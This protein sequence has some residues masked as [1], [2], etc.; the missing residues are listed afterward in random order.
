MG[1]AELCQRRRDAGGVRNLERHLVGDA[2]G[3]EL[4]LGI[5]ERHRGRGAAEV[6]GEGR[7]QAGQGQQQGRLADAVRPDQGDEF[8]A[9]KVEVDAADDRLTRTPHRHLAR[10][11][12]HVAE[13]RCWLPG[14][15]PGQQSEVR[16]R[17]QATSDAADRD[18]LGLERQPVARP[19][20]GVAGP[21]QH[22]G[23]GTGRHDPP[24]LVERQGALGQPVDASRS[25][26][27]VKTM[28]DDHRGGVPA[29]RA[30]QHVTE[31]GDAGRVEHRGRLVEHQQLRVVDAGGR[32]P[33]PLQ[34]AARQFGGVPVPQPGRTD[35]RQGG[36][37]AGVDERRVDRGTLQHQS[38]LLFDG[39]QA[40]RCSGILAEEAQLLE[41]R[42]HHAPG[43]VRGDR[44]RHSPGQQVQQRRLARA[45][46]AEH[47][48][49]RAGRELGRHGVQN[50]ALAPREGDAAPID[51]GRLVSGHR[52]PAGRARWRSCR[53]PRCG[54]AGRRSPWPAGRPG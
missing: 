40:D 42:T 23:G 32:Q 36:V 5:L 15:V 41:G 13:R 20:Q 22:L 37:D 24:C 45:G 18:Q 7:Q 21:V 8:T 19:V 25:G 31:G 34:F 29:G 1:E 53:R 39:R 26:Q 50:G 52:R 6:S 27:L 4:V 46:G 16:G 44:A 38:Q 43:D 30:G 51:A 48:R 12:H 47:Q 11:Q 54:P 33:H 35:R 3:D 2:A 10:T 49:R 28:L 9:T 14:A 17:V